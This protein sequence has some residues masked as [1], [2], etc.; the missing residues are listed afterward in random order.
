MHF[1]NEILIPFYLGE[2]SELLK[3][4]LYC[5]FLNN[6]L[7]YTYCKNWKGEIKMTITLPSKADH[8]GSWLRKERIKQA[9]IKMENKKINQQKIKADED[10]ENEKILITK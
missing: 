1:C 10:E 9:R 2:I 8:V 4:K 3:V 5:V 7:K 6:N